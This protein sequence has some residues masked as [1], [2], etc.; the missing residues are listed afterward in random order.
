MTE[1]D[2]IQPRVNAAWWMTLSAALIVFGSTTAG[3][4]AESSRNPLEPV[5]TSSPRATFLAFLDNAEKAY[6][7]W[8]LHAGAAETDAQVRRALRTLDL[9]QVGEALFYEIG[10]ADALYLYETL[11]RIDPPP[12]D[13]IPTRLR[14]RL[15]A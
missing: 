10:I 2:A 6:R 1:D 3:F 11:S 13:S 15:S 9:R 8:R 12:L 14:L 7:S 4:A 5:D